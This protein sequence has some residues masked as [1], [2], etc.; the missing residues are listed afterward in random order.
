MLSCHAVYAVATLDVLLTTDP[1]YLRYH[2]VS[3]SSSDEGICVAV[4][5]W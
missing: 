5:Y 2:K 3:Q 1:Y 4:N